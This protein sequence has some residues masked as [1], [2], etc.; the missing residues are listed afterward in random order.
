VLGCKG[1]GFGVGGFVGESGTSGFNS[2]LSKAV[3]DKLNYVTY[4]NDMRVQSNTTMPGRPRDQMVKASILVAT[5][6]IIDDEGPAGLSVDAIAKRAGTSRP[7]LYRW[8]RSKG[9][10]LLDALLEVTS[11]QVSY[12]QQAKLIDDLKLHARDYV[13]L[14]VGRYGAAYR[15]V[16]AEGLADA[17]FMALVR[18]RLI[19][20][21]RACTKGRLEAAIKANELPADTDL[22]ALIDALY[23]PF[24]YRLILGHQPLSSEFSDTHIEHTIKGYI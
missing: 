3:I 24:L 12:G 21:R 23:A 1:R 6:G 4:C 19:G 15:A 7:T 18:I 22:E 9:E 20:P 13:T 5:I 16:F 14:L 2:R 10:I 17:E 11:E 8:W